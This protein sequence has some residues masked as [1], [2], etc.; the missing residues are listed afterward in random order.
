MT[1]K[2]FLR[3]FASAILGFRG[4]GFCAALWC[5]VWCNV[6]EL[7]SICFGRVLFAT[8]A[9]SLPCMTWCW[10]VSVTSGFLFGRLFA[11]LRNGFSFVT[12]SFRI[13]K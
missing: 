9:G 4:P 2:Q 6:F 11:M 8:T 3:P 13:A 7:D 1:T 5:V 10:D 12:N